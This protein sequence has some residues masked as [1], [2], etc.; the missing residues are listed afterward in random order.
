[1]TV[2]RVVRPSDVDGAIEVLASSRSTA[3]PLAGGVAWMLEQ[4]R[5]GTLP[6]VLVD[7]SA[8]P[9]LSGVERSS[10]GGLTIGAMTRLAA[11]ERDPLVREHAPGLVEAVHAVGSVRIRQQ[12]TLGGNIAAEVPRHDPPPMLV[13]LDASIRVAGVGGERET[14]IVG[15]TRSSGD[16]ILDVRVSPTAPTSAVAYR[17][18]D[19][20][21][22]S[23]VARV[24]AAVRLD[25]AEDGTIGSS[26]VV[27][28]A[29][30]EGPHRCPEAEAEL[31]GMVAEPSTIQLA[32][33]AAEQ[34]VASRL[35]DDHDDA[36]ATGIIVRRALLV[37]VDRSS[38]VAR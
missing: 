34:A 22:G 16:L 31:A 1:M 27:L 10:D 15:Y 37:A 19:V 14:P 13:A 3:A 20:T 2:T 6:A 25:R 4:A 33:R 8:I 36:I 7:L 28:M 9:G 23:R 5:G 11:V 38:G 18:L 21:V 26:R 12:V 35:G 32:A 30:D 17:T 29:P 24:G